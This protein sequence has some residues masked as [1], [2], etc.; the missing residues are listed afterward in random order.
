MYEIIYLDLK[1]IFFFCLRIP[2]RI[3][4]NTCMMFEQ[5]DLIGSWKDRIWK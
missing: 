4:R 3:M 5:F 1:L 2:G